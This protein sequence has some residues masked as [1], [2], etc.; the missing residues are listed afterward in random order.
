LTGTFNGWLDRT[1]LAWP[2]RWLRAFF[3]LSRTSH[4]SIFNDQRLDAVALNTEQ[5]VQELKDRLRNT[6]AKLD[7]LE[8]LLELCEQPG[9]AP[10][11]CIEMN[12]S[13]WLSRAEHQLHQEAIGIGTDNNEDQFYSFY[14]AIAGDQCA[15]LY[16][17]YD[18]YISYLGVNIDSPVLD[19]GCGSGEFLD[20]LRDKKYIC[21]GVDLDANEVQRAH[22]KGHQVVCDTA[23]R[24][25]S[26]VKSGFSAV[27][28]FQVIEH[29]DWGEIKSLLQSIYRALIVDGCC[30]VETI[31]LQHPLALNC[32]FTDPTHRLPVSDTL[33]CFLFE[34][35]GFDDVQ[36]I[37]LSPEKLPGIAL[38]EPRR[39]YKN[40]AVVGYKKTATLA[41]ENHT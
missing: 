27:T 40:Y 29:M 23:H 18:Q 4:Q 24:Y 30:I 22:T 26:T 2:L 20:Y 10:P 14:S 38:S 39:I 3:L 12:G 33:M 16:R 15:L 11:F 36:L 19:L 6:E 8:P 32:F 13:G 25:L 5:Q 7:R 21:I 31:N 35:V 9:D 41:I 37:Y 17:H 34:W 28:L 1:R